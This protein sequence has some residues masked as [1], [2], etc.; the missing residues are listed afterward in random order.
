MF[1]GKDP[2]ALGTVIR[3]SVELAFELNIGGGGGNRTISINVESVTYRLFWTLQPLKTAPQAEV[4][5][6]LS[7][8]GE[9]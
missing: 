9:L 5:Y 2:P 4:R 7:T 8:T 3:G 1:A 6:S